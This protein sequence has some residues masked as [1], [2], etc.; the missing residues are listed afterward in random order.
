[1]KRLFSIFALLL[2]FCAPAFAL[3]DAEYL[4]WKKNS[5]EFREADK[6]MSESYNSCKKILP[7]SDFKAIHDEQIEWIKL[8]RDERA[9]EIMDDKGCSCL[10]AYTKATEE[11][12]HEL[13][14]NIQMYELWY[15]QTYGDLPPSMK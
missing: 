8:G 5:R 11:R 1:M 14:H 9:K 15:T 13:Y 10:E 12:D 3:S 2:V 4:K 7:S 6:S